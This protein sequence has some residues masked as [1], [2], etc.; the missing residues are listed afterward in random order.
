MEEG[1]GNRLRRR[2]VLLLNGSY[3]PLNICTIRR[4]IEL[5]YLGKAELVHSC[6]GQVIKGERIAIP[7]PSV[8]R[9]KYYVK[10]KRGELPLTKRNILRRDGYTCQYC[11]SKG[12]AMTVD[13]IIPRSQ[14][15]RDDWENLVCACHACNHIK[16]E[17][18]PEEAG[19]TLLRRPR[20]P[21]HIHLLLSQIPIPDERWKSYLFL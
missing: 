15:G 18:R 12:E 9:L 6:D 3:E 5:L 14:G 8:I 17:R 10:V 20:K 1:S 7:R 13:H 16:G 11:G 19:L 2:A 4:G 21:S